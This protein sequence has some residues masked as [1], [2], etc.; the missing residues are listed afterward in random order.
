MTISN[1]PS[2]TKLPN[3]AAMHKRQFEKMDS[4]DDYMNKKADRIKKLFGTP[5][6]THQATKV[7]DL[8]FCF[9]STR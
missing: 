8:A 4:L 6:K 5:T 3:F 1:Q 2:R 7:S 9:L